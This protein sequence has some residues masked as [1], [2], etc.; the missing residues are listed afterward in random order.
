MGKQV[1]DTGGTQLQRP[2]HTLP[3]S[4]VAEELGADRKQGLS[5]ADAQKRV[6]QYGR[7]ELEGGGGVQPAKIL[8]RQIANAMIL[9][10][11]TTTPLKLSCLS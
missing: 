8:V 1:D 10:M 11:H 2:A 9:V 6:E 4:H 7:N 5:D 3:Y